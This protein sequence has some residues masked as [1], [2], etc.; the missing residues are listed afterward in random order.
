[1]VGELVPAAELDAALDGSDAT[2][3]GAPQARHFHFAVGAIGY[4]RADFSNQVTLFC[5]AQGLNQLTLEKL[6][7]V[8]AKGLYRLALP[9]SAEKASPLTG[10]TAH[11]NFGPLDKEANCE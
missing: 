5:A 9:S 1:M 6:V 4:R 8:M 11:L 7:P 2:V 3:V 10:L